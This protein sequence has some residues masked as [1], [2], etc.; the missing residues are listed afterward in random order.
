MV[1]AAEHYRSA[2]IN[3]LSSS[4]LS[5]SLDFAYE[6]EQPQTQWER[7][8]FVLEQQQLVHLEQQRKQL[9]QREQQQEQQKTLQEKLLLLSQ[10]E[11]NNW[12]MNQA[13]P[14]TT[15]TPLGYQAWPQSA[16][17]AAGAAAAAASVRNSPVHTI[18]PG[19]IRP[20]PG[21]ETA[22]FM[23]N[24]NNGC[25]LPAVGDAVA[26]L[27]VNHNSNNHIDHTH[28]ATTQQQQQQVDDERRMSLGMSTM[29]TQYDP[30]TSP[31]SIWSDNWRQRNNHMN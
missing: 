9:Q 7:S 17:T 22:N 25:Q 23:N 4:S 11:S 21:L 12:P 10:M 28:N 19:V 15:W 24:N 3:T 2:F 6:R 30:F 13:T 18:S 14:T 1:S 31:S 16:V 20:P 8:N 26:P 29:P 5:I 27:Q